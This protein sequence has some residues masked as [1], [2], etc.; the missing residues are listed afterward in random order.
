MCSTWQEGNSTQT[1]LQLDEKIFGQL[2][3][4]PCL[5]SSTTTISTALLCPGSTVTSQQI[6]EEES[7]LR[8]CPMTTKGQK[9]YLIA[10]F[11]CK[12][13]N[14]AMMIYMF[15]DNSNKYMALYF[16]FTK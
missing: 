13:K 4:L 3:G 8:N 10:F 14:L 16:C 9:I 15:K 7:S 6:T 2:Q 12:L 11:M 1:E 5:L